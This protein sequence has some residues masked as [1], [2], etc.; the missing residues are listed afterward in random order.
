MTQ[1]QLADLLNV[2]AR[3]VQDY[4]H[5]VTVPWRYFD[6]LEQIF[7]KSLAWFL[8]GDPAPPMR[9]VDERHD[10]TL[11]LHD[12]LMRTLEELRESQRVIMSRL[13]QL[14]RRMP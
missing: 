6:R 12:E 1:A 11:R 10:F 8:H 5:G 3:S 7:G 13:D 14:D 4:E 9:I 2:S